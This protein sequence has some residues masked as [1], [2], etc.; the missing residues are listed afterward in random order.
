M[1]LNKLLVSLALVATGSVMVAC[2][3]GS[4]GGNSNP[5]P[6]VNPIT[7]TGGAAVPPGSTTGVAVNATAG[8]VQV[9]GSS[10]YTSIQLNT[11]QT[12]SLA[13]MILNNGGES[14][15]TFAPQANG[16][17]AVY[18]TIAGQ[19]ESVLIITP[20]PTSVQDKAL[21]ST[22]TVTTI[23]LTESSVVELQATSATILGVTYTG[24]QY[25]NG[26]N[27]IINAKVNGVES[28][29]MLPRA[30]C[31]NG[32]ISVV[33]SYNTHGTDYI[34]YGTESGQVCV[35]AGNNL[36]ES[37][38]SNRAPTTGGNAY[39]ATRLTALGYPTQVNTG[40]NIVGYWTNAS[41][42]YKVYGQ[43][44]SNSSVVAQGFLNTTTT[45]SQN[46]NGSSSP[47]AFTNVPAAAS[48]TST[49]TDPNGNLW[50]VSNG[51]V[52]VLRNGNTAWTFTAPTA[53]PTKVQSNGTNQGATV[54]T[55]GSNVY[56]A[57]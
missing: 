54:I 40:S 32:K 2:G 7:P 24:V 57:S 38:L 5:V 50:A 18:P 52:Y 44:V 22:A 3:S 51:K 21:T 4:T 27:V 26:N 35:Y 31:P 42:V 30:Q 9:P 28:S 1:K 53:A 17:V 56:N 8:L 48:I 45:A 23:T 41:G 11:E 47:V 16:T 20:N 33:S 29:L 15:L 36:S 10:G 25:T 39:T 12:A 34:G 19:G 6:S 14:Q 13:A 37:N 46:E 55:A 43:Y 49:Y